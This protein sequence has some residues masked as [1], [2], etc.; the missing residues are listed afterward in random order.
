MNFIDQLAPLAIK[1][2]KANGILPSLICAQGI[3]ES[4]SGTS[5]LARNANN[6]FG[7]KKGSGWT[8]ETYTKRTAEQDK[9]GNVTY[10]D[11]AFRKYPSYEGCVIDLVHKYTHGTGW[12]DYN[13]YAAILGQTDYKLVITALKAASYATDVK[14][15]T[16]LIEQ[17]EKYGLTNM[18]RRSITWSK[19]RWMP[20]MASTHLAN[21]PRRMSVNGLSTAKS[22]WHAQQL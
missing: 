7:I 21:D 1:H 15:E 6:L 13:R 20:G 16:K 11:A 5:E 14:Y 8:G 9:D 10:I 17:I 4:D 19:L 3:L 18:T 12:E 22:F 2:G